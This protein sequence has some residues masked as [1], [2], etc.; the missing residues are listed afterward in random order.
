MEA[1]FGRPGRALSFG[2][3]RVWAWSCHPDPL[4]HKERGRRLRCAPEEFTPDDAGI[5]VKWL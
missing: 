5:K 4:L 1:V 3:G 2:L